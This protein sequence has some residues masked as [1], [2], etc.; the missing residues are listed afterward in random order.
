[1]LE[2]IT[3]GKAFIKHLVPQ[4]E[5]NMYVS[6]NRPCDITSQMRC[7]TGLYCHAFVQLLEVTNFISREGNAK[8]SCHQSNGSHDH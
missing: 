4:D 6:S 2:L 8:T 1:M 7:T 5:T 3:T